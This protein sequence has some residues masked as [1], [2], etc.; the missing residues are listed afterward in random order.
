MCGV[1]A[2][3]SVG[4]KPRRA[5]HI[6]IS[7]EQIAPGLSRFVE[8]R[9]S[10]VVPN[11]KARVAPVQEKHRARNLGSNPERVDQPRNNAL[12]APRFSPYRL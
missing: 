4:R 11:F 1:D 6:D 10:K 8:R 5:Q 7:L 3:S 12:G 2:D 9:S